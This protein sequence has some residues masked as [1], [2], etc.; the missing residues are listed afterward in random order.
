MVKRRNSRQDA[1]REIVRGKSIKT[2]HALVEELRG[3]R[4]CLYA[5]NSF[6]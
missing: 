2:Q 6:S 1:I 3:R 4:I 5:S